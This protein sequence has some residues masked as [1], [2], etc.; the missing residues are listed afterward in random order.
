VVS[1]SDFKG[2]LEL[3]VDYNQPVPIHDGYT[4]TDETVLCSCPQPSSEI[5]WA[6]EFV[7]PG[8]SF[9]ITLF[10]YEGDVC[11]A[12]QISRFEQTIIA[13]YTS[14]PIVLQGYYSQSHS[15]SH[16]NWDD[17]FL[18]E[19]QL[20]P[21]IPQKILDELRAKN[22]RFF[23]ADVRTGTISTYGFDGGP[24]NPADI[25]GDGDADFRD[26]SGFAEHWLDSVCDDCG[27]SDLTGDGRVRLDDLREFAEYW[28]AGLQ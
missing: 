25:D 21:G 4:N 8:G 3:Q 12:C 22:I 5:P 7:G 28:L 6:C 17:F 10:Y 9:I 1:L 15:S 18:F 11:F 24:F 26:F 14:E 16:H 19:P 27:G 20:E 13:G 23:L 2:T